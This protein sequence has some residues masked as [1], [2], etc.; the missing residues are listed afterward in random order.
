MDLCSDMSRYV[1]IYGHEVDQ[2]FVLILEK[3]RLIAEMC[4][5]HC[6]AISIDLGTWHCG[7]L[8]GCG[9]LWRE[10]GICMGYAFWIILDHFGS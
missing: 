9:G 10:H 1:A 6:S 4:A 3:G 2:V 8:R 5:V 7:H